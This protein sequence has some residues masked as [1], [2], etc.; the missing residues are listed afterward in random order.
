M[1]KMRLGG[2]VLEE[3]S[4]EAKLGPRAE[5]FMKISLVKKLLLTLVINTRSTRISSL[6]LKQ[7]YQAVFLMRA[8]SYWKILTSQN[9][10]N[11]KLLL[12]S[13]NYRTQSLVNKGFKGLLRRTHLMKCK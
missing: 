6:M 7:K 12:L 4:R 1:R 5:R 13:L 2:A 10:L 9:R 11:R 3:W 8:L